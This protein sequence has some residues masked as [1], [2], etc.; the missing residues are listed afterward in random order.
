MPQI[1]N[2]VNTEKAAR[3]RLWISYPWVS[4]EERD[5]AYLI[6]QLKDASIEATYDSLQ[7]LPN[8]H[9]CERTAQRLSGIGFDG[10]L[11]ILTHQCFTRRICTD[12]LMAAIE[13]VSQHMGPDF[14]MIGLMSDIANHQVPL[15]LRVRPCIS[16][17]DPNWRQQI[18][19]VLKR[20]VPQRL[21]GM[22]RNET[23]FNWKM[24]PGYCGDP[25]MT[26]V[27]VSSKGESVPYWRFA[28]PKSARAIGWGQG[29]SGGRKISH[30][31]IAEATGS[32]KHGGND[33]TW[34]GAAN[35]I[36]SA[37][38]AYAV[39]SEPLPDFIGFGSAASP[40]GPPNQ[41]EIFWPKN[42]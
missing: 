27:E 14:P 36:S 34:F 21:K 8:T 25:S 26:A 9:L 1:E 22:M 17:S 7:L 20:Y 6:S 31:R 42:R 12:E 38:S 41:L 28:I 15:K 4:K 3:P 24:H 11:Y 19:D 37:E 30:T 18:S 2:M 23:Q 29:P 16:L 40:F 32:G 5:F 39:F 13:K 35:S 10:W 33:I